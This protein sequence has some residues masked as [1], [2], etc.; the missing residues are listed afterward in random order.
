VLTGDQVGDDRP[1]VHILPRAGHKV[2]LDLGL[3][4]VLPESTHEGHDAVMTIQMPAL[5]CQC[6]LTQ[7]K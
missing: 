4:R 6:K 1:H 2:R 5:L 3:D 7:V